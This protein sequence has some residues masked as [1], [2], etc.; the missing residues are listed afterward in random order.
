MV[1]KF[2]VDL[3]HARRQARLT[4]RWRTQG[5][6]F[7][8]YPFSG[9]KKAYSPRPVCASS[10]YYNS[11]LK[12]NNVF[13]RFP[14]LRQLSRHVSFRPGPRQFRLHRLQAARA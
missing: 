2:R 7:E 8:F 4:V 14:H 9:I 5:Q 1:K 12:M 11:I 10:Y 6:F 13:T 3:D